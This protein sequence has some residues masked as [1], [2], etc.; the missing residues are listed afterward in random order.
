MGQ[1][2]P[3]RQ[4]IGRLFWRRTIERHQR[5]GHAGEAPK[6]RTPPVANRCD[7]NLIGAAADVV[8]E[9]MNVHRRSVV[10]AKTEAPILRGRYVGSSEARREDRMH[11]GRSGDRHRI[12][13]KK[14]LRCQLLHSFCTIHAQL[15]HN[16]LRMDPEPQPSQQVE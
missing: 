5:R 12:P 15:F 6:L 9:A 1:D 2:E 13:T 3:P 8:L 14:N 7:F 16:P 11:R 10:I 4:L